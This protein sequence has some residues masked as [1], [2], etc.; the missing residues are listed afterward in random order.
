MHTELQDAPQACTL[1]TAWMVVRRCSQGMLPTAETARSACDYLLR[2]AGLDAASPSV[3]ILR[4][5]AQGALTEDGVREK[6]AAEVDRLMALAKA[7]LLQSV[8]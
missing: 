7:R 5:A 4:H 3:Q 2:H 6:A 8:H 1:R